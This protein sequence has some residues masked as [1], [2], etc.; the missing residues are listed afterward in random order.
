MAE[1]TGLDSLRGQEIFLFTIAPIPALGPIQP[2]I[3]WVLGSPTPAVERH[4][5][6]ADHSP[7]SLTEVKNGGAVPLFP[8]TSSCRDTELIKAR[9]KYVLIRRI[10]LGFYL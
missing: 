3:Q 7:P 6:E 4:V 5:R 8:H 10:I 2:P 9:D 1:E